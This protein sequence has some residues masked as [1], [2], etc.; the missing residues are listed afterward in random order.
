MTNS[1]CLMKVGQVYNRLMTSEEID[2]ALKAFKV[3]EHLIVNIDDDLR[4]WIAYCAMA[5]HNNFD[6]EINR[7]L[8]DKMN[9]DTSEYKKYIEE[10]LR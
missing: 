8:R 4:D 3:V 10:A 7:L 5:N 2:G 1:Q 6:M 9:Y